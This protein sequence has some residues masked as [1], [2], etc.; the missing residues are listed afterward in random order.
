MKRFLLIICITLLLIVVL[1]V[2]LIGTKTPQTNLNWEQSH[3]RIVSSEYNDELLT[4]YNIR[5]WTYASGTILEEKWLD[6]VAVNPDELTGV[7]FMLEPF[8]E[9]Q[10]VGHTYLTFAFADGN[11]LSFSVEARREVGEDYSAFQGLLR[12]YELSYTWGTERD[13][14]T[15]RLLYLQH[16]L[17]MYPLT[18]DTEVG[19]QILLSVA[20]RTNTIATEPRFYNTLFANCTNILAQEM[21]HAFPDSVPYDLSWNLPGYSDTFLMKQGYV[22]QLG[23]TD[24][25]MMRYDLTQYREYIETIATTS[26]HVFSEDIRNLLR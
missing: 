21:N 19:K 24:E 3:S 16:P 26:H 9:W 23:T 10:A 5:D 13:L 17:R 18:I 4:F 2:L 11:N 8:S 6:E 15:R 12:K 22:E 7:W 20:E 1:W 14:L 25:T